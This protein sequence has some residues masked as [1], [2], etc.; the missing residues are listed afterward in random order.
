MSLNPY[1]PVLLE[2][3]AAAK[4]RVPDVPKCLYDE[5]GPELSY[6]VEWER[7]PYRKMSELFAVPKEAFPPPEQLTDD[8][9]QKI[10]DAI[11][12]L[13]RAYNFDP[14]FPEELPA[15]PAYRA[16]V[17]YWEKEVQFISEGTMHIEFCSYEPEEC[18]FPKEFC[19]CKDLPDEYMD[20]TA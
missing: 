15:R 14:V 18:P 3:L 1:I 4:L 11:I 2:D 8:D 7:A 19:M 17:S 6:V 16:L 10:V 5:F 12:D 20:S 13:W 9:V